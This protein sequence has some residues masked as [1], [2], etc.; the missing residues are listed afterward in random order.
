MRALEAH[1]P[2]VAEKEGFQDAVARE[3]NLRPQSVM[4][5]VEHFQQVGMAAAD[6]FR[7]TKYVKI[8]EEEEAHEPRTGP[9]AAF[10]AGEENKRR[11]TRKQKGGNWGMRS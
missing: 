8:V 5:C 6:E 9:E 10:L 11:V 4:A 7:R 3:L 1:I 2:L